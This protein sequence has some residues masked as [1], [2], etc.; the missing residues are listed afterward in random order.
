MMCSSWALG[1]VGMKKQ[2]I[3]VGVGSGFE[4]QDLT[5]MRDGLVEMALE[6]FTGAL[7]GDGL[8]LGQF[9]IEEIAQNSGVLARGVCGPLSGRVNGGGDVGGLEGLLFLPFFGEDGD[10]IGE[11]EVVFIL[12]LLGKEE[13]FEA[14]RGRRA[15]GERLY[16]AFIDEFFVLFR[17]RFDG[18]ADKAPPGFET[19]LG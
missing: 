7:G 1:D 19:G 5:V 3:G 11:I 6:T 16:L 18:L 9:G 4:D 14:D 17:G 15:F 10:R 12:I 2:Q 13:F 8:I